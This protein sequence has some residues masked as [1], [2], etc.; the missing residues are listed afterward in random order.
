MKTCTRCGESKPLTKF[1]KRS[2]SRDGLRTNCK[3][4]ANI[5]SAAHREQARAR[6]AQWCKDNPERHKANSS[7]WRAANR[8]KERKRHAK[9]SA[10]NPD[11]VKAGNAKW[12][13]KNPDIRKAACA[14]WRAENADRHKAYQAKYRAENADAYR[15][16]DQNRRASES[17]GKLS[18]GLAERLIKLQ[19]G[20]CACCK[21]PLGDDYHLDHIMPLTLGGSNEDSNMQL[22]R[23]KCNLNKSAKHPV[24]FMQQ[25][26]YLI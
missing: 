26:G 15:A 24:E 12:Y 22:L 7:K 6:T 20:K 16:Y 3:A 18:P 5:Y 23:A 1:S 13:A 17:G 4:C 21:Q 10:E 19:R 14:R 9:Y 8:D 2:S 25:R 11:K